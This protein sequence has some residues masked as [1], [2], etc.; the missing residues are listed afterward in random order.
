[1]AGSLERTGVRRLQQA[2]SAAAHSH[3]ND[4]LQMLRRS[5][6]AELEYQMRQAWQERLA[7]A[8]TN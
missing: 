2:L 1:M 6:A 3:S 4:P 7:R 8:Q 5:Q